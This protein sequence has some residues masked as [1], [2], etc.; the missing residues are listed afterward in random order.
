MQILK[1]LFIIILGVLAQGVNAQVDNQDFIYN[2]YVYTENIKSVQFKGTSRQTSNFPV[3]QLNRGNLLFSFDELAEDAREYTYR[4]VHCDRNW[5]PSELD[6]EDYIEGFDYEEIRDYEFSQNTYV[7]YVHY[8]LQLPNKYYK[9]TI[10]GN[11]LLIIYDGEE[12][13]GLPVITRRFMVTEQS[14][15]VRVKQKS[16]IRS[17]RFKSH[18]EF[19]FF[20]NLREV[21]VSDPKS[22]IYV[23]V[24]QNGRW[25]SAIDNLQANYL[26]RGELNFNF[27]D[28]VVFPGLKEFRNFDIRK[29]NF[30]TEWVH[31]IDLNIDGS[32]VLLKLG[33]PR[34]YDHY[35][36]RPDINGS[37][38]ISNNDDDGF[39]TRND[40]NINSDYANVI[41]TLKMSEL[42]PDVDVYPIGSFS[43][44]APLP[45]Y[46]MYYDLQ[47]NSYICEGYFKQGYYDY[48]Y[49]IISEDGID[50]ETLEGNS[51]ESGNSY[52]FLVYYSEF[53]GR[54]DR[55]IAVKTYDSNN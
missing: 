55:L 27:N 39:I 9:W 30:A 49:A 54:Y 50:I 21:S 8:D 14:V 5:K 22:E 41:F 12:G 34:T 28:R 51:Y 52:N 7:D 18:H 10:S 25:E 35:H 26:S 36:T 16:P 20:I 24:L 15:D 45:E 33:E 37:F 13:E 48:L 11:Y 4:V 3:I 23:H 1:S 40:A 2:D 32:D 6:R 42:A 38:Y 43:G 53:S 17:D 44:W 46:K 19:D 31:S 47:Y 29:L